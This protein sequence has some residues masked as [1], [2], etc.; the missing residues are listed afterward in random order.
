MMRFLNGFALQVGQMDRRIIQLIF[1]IL[2]LLM[3]VIGAGAPADGGIGT[4]P[5][6]G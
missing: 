6:G 1:F 5:A 2:V 3:F 4:P